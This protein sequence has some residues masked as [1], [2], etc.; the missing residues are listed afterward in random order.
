VLIVTALVPAVC[1]ASIP[2][3]SAACS[4]PPDPEL[5]AFI[6]VVM[7]VAH[8]S[9]KILIEPAENVSVPLTEVIRI[10][11]NVPPRFDIPPENVEF[12]VV[13]ELANP[14]LIT[15]VLPVKFDIWQ[16]PKSTEPGVRELRVINPTV[17]DAEDVAIGANPDP[18][19]LYP[20]DTIPPEVPSRIKKELVPLA[21]TPLNITVIRLIQDGIP[22]K[23]MLVPLVEATAVPATMFVDTP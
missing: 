8:Y 23:S 13:A 18:V 2:V 3:A 14:P 9:Y 10:R 12:S 15:Q 20:E 6:V 16:T 7:L 19:E 5:L 11:S 21:L 22:V 17:D 4:K 1:R